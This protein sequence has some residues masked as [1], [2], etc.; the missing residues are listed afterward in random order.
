MNGTFKL[1]LTAAI[2]IATSAFW[3]NTA[4]AASFDCAKAQTKVEKVICADPSISD[5]DSR[6]GKVYG[7]DLAKANP[8]QKKQLIADERHWLKSV[9]DRCATQACLKQAYT[10]RLADLKAFDGT[11]L[12]KRKI[13]GRYIAQPVPLSATN[14]VPIAP[15][16]K[17]LVANFNQFRDVPFES[18]HPRLSPKYPQFRRLNWK[19]M[20]W[21]RTLAEMAYSTCP[22]EACLK[23]HGWPK[24]LHYWEKKTAPLRKA[25]KILLW[26]VQVDL[27]GDG[28]HETLIRLTH[29]FP[30]PFFRNSKAVPVSPPKPYSL[31]IDSKI[32]M[33]PS[34]YPKMA[35][36]F[37]EGP[38]QGVG[39]FVT[40]IIQN[41][42]NNNAPYLA[43][44]W[45]RDRMGMGVGSFELSQSA[46]P[47]DFQPLCNVRWI[48]RG[49]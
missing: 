37:N 12:P 9:R 31:Y 44:A 32:Y 1:I 40:D 10:Q 33:L 36:T 15:V 7:Q 38:G 26:R 5:L 21:N 24:Y 3:L 27:L 41:V 43:L 35:N 39:L 48:P 22:N 28:R 20:P 25:G 30:P 34:P 11:Q 42:G 2:G 6:L 17:T 23:K 46:L 13:L 29:Y 19:P 47:Y 4:H 14:F 8:E 49:K 16:C 18:N 45:S